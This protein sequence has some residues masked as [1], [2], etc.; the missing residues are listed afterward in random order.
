MA[1]RRPS[2]DNPP[3]NTAPHARQII[4]AAL[5]M[6]AF[7]AAPI[8][9]QQAVSDSPTL[10]G[11]IEAAAKMLQNNPRLKR[12]TEQQLI[13]RV[14]FVAANTLVLLLHELG[15]VHIA[16]M[17][18][19]VLGREE[20]AADTFAA[21][22]MLKIGTSFSQHE[23]AQAAKGWFLN[24][25]RDQQTGEKPLYYGEHNLNQQRAYQILCLMVGSD[26]NK[27]KSLADE[28]KVPESR[29]KTCERDFAKTSTAW[30]AVLMPWHLEPGQ[31]ETEIKVVYEDGQ[32][33]YDAFANMFRSIRFLETVAEFYKEH[34]RW[35]RSFTLKMEICGHP[36]ADYDDEARVVTMC[37]ET[38]FDFA[39]LYR[40]YVEP[41][42]AAAAPAA[43]NTKA[44]RPRP[45]ISQ[46]RQRERSTASPR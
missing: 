25:L 30:G 36:G 34:Y 14:E 20:D 42:P 45:P 26:P 9:A 33:T 27:F 38:P 17:N 44:T 35:P 2:G 29:Q 7:S 5:G 46:R 37:Y 41:P 10:H 32:R 28:M 11:R 39:E 16:E 4:C 21:L 40:A 24:D 8:S 22:T 18:L 6:L 31:P 12:L 1:S 23:L 43:G 13:D 15:H 19:Q 3:G